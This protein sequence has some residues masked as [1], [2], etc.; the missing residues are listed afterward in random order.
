VVAYTTPE[1][2]DLPSEAR[3]RLSRGGPL[4][5]YGVAAAFARTASYPFGTYWVV[6]GTLEEQ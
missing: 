2:S 5:A 6:L 4:R 1:P 3:R